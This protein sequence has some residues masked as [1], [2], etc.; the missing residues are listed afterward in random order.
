MHVFVSHSRVN[1]SSA[2]RLCDEL[3]KRNVETWLD[4]RDAAIDAE[5]SQQVISAIRSAIGFVFLIGPPGRD[6]PGQTFEWQQVVD[7]ELYLDPAKPLIPVLIG[8]PEI[9]GFLRARHS[10]ALNHTPESCAEVAGQIVNALKDPALSVDQEKL[11]LGRKARV[12]ALQSM[13][14]YSQVLGEEDVK[15]AGLRAVK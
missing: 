7:Q 2:F 8:E 12:Q 14:E 11:E 5:W 9:P 6:D 15:R 4:V 1:S 3:H 10:V 13:R